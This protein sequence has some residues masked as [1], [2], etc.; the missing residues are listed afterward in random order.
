MTAKSV[1]VGYLAA[2]GTALPPVKWQKVNLSC[3]EEGQPIKICFT[4]GNTGLVPP[5][6]YR[7]MARQ[8]LRQWGNELAEVRETFRS[9]GSYE[10]AFGSSS[11]PD[12][13]LAVT[14][15]V[16]PLLKRVWN[17]PESMMLFHLP[18]AVFLVLGGIELKKQRQAGCDEEVQ[19]VRERLR[20]EEVSSDV[21]C[22]TLEERFCPGAALNPVAPARLQDMSTFRQCACS[23]ACPTL[24]SWLHKRDKKL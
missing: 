15:E 13:R 9:P 1:I 3:R 24:L 2:T 19:A 5:F 16:R 18:A 6:R 11:E 20:S 21:D 4:S 23:R 7:V 8:P 12:L 10:V 14:V 17:L 22:S